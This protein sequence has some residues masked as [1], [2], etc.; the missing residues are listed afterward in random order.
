MHNE[1]VIRLTAMGDV[2]L[3]IPTVRALAGNGSRIHWILS[4]KWRHLAT[5][6]PAIVH[7]VDTFADFLRLARRLRALKPIRTHDLQGKFSS[8][9]FSFLLG[10]RISRYRK[11]DLWEN[12]KAAGGAFPL[13]N[14]DTRPV[15]KRYMDTAE[16]GHFDPNP[17]LFLSEHYLHEVQMKILENLGL[18]PYS[19]TLC[20]PGASKP[21][22]IFPLSG[23]K[24]IISQMKPPVFIIGNANEGHGKNLYNDLRGKLDLYYLPGFIALSKGLVTTDSGPMHLARAVDVPVAAFFFQTDPSLGFSPIPGNKV[25]IF[26][27]PLPCKPCSLHGQRDTCPLKTWEC[28]RYHWPSVSS[29][30]NDF[31][32]KAA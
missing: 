21:G 4:G 5:F 18:K 30:L 19:Y 16:V 1:V 9:F 12:L 6:L 28:R 13:S 7:T 8:I 32:E 26:S 14:A 31:L 3:A 27:I 20:H 25:K 10:G 11:R 22:K 2:I 23:F 24:S 29:E 15:W 17:G